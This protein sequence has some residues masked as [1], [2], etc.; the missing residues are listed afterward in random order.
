M[1]NKKKCRDICW[2]RLKKTGQIIRF[3]LENMLLMD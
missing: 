2:T 1:Q 3:A